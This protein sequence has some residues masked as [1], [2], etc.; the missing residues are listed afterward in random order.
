MLAVPY[1]GTGIIALYKESLGKQKSPQGR[2]YKWHDTAGIRMTTRISRSRHR[3]AQAALAGPA[4]AKT[5]SSVTSPHL[6]L[7]ALLTPELAPGFLSRLSGSWDLRKMSISQGRLAT[8]CL[9]CA[10][11][12]WQRG[13]EVSPYN[14]CMLPRHTAHP[15]QRE[16]EEVV[17]N[18]SLHTSKFGNEVCL[19]WAFASFL[20][21][22]IEKRG[23]GRRRPH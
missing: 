14:F 10:H 16:G 4:H 22:Q 12:S 20:I 6:H 21:H 19:L 18:R 15:Q 9:M 23:K 2:G 1:P 17:A 5:W 11:K 7:F 3:A 13:S 8:V